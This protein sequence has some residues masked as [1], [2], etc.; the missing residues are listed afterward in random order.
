MFVI[1][2]IK[3]VKNSV[4]GIGRKMPRIL[5][6]AMLATLKFWHKDI[7]PLHF[8]HGNKQR[9]NYERRTNLYLNYIKPEEGEGEGKTVLLILK[10]RSPRDAKYRASFTAT[11]HLG[12]CR[13][14]MP[15]Y[16]THPFTGTIV[17]PHT[18]RSRH[19]SHQPNKPKELR[20]VT[21]GDRTQ[22]IREC[23]KHI[24]AG[25]QAALTGKA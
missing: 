1:L 9:Y 20:A 18:G 4:R 24:V 15:P 8:R 23:K 3:V 11:Q 19:I 5:R 25:T 2:D 6:D 21:S 17:D 7:M 22:M 14:S 12:R 13:M 16:F 10:G